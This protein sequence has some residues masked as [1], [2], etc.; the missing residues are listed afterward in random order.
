MNRNTI[1]GTVLFLGLAGS[2]QAQNE[3]GPKCGNET[4]KGS[5]GFQFTG[6]RPAQFVPVGKP[7]FVGQ[8]EQADGIVVRLFDGK[9]NFT[10][11]E[12]SK[13]TTTGYIP[14]RPGRGTYVVNSDCSVEVTVLIAPGVT[15]VTRGVV[16]D[17]GKE[18]RGFAAS[19][20]E[21]SIRFV[22]RQMK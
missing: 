5:Y 18:I 15:A 6:L 8:L 7:G 22:A 4:L 20:E 10:Q 21:A 9:G 14:A 17:G 2:A 19:P 12:T 3:E 1:M 16:V 13:G 11:S